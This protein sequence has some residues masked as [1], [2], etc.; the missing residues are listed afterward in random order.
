MT[1]K[2]KV[3]EAIE[4]LPKTM[5]AL[6]VGVYK[7]GLP[8]DEVAASLSLTMDDARKLLGQAIRKVS[9]DVGLT[10]ERVEELFCFL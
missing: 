9:D 2:Q 7:A 6:V 5:N 1:N 3:A 4:K 10:E 8:A